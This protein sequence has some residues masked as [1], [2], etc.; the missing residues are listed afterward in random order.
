LD[1][2]AAAGGSRPEREYLHNRYYRGKLKSV[3]YEVRGE[4]E[5]NL[6][7]RNNERQNLEFFPLFSFVMVF[8]E[9]TSISSNE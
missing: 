7:V 6:C 5:F 4:M 3:F 1:I 9:F 2:D 8:G